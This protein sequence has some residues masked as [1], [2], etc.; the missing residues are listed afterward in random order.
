MPVVSVALF[1]LFFSANRSNFPDPMAI[2]WGLSGEPDGFGSLDGQLLM[3]SLV[4]LLVGGLWAGI[5]YLR[6]IP[7]SIR[8]LFLAITGVIWVL[9]FV[10]FGY[11]FLIQLGLSDAREAQINIVFFIAV[12]SLPLVLLPWLMSKPKIELGDQLGVYYWRVPILRLS[13]KEVS[14]VEVVEARA[15]DFGG[16]GIRYANR[17]TAFLPNSGP[18]VL[19]NLSGSER[20][21][22][23]TDDAS[24]IAK[25]IRKRSGL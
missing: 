6:R 24:G 22:I 3:V 10:V 8:V 18:G 16:W 20:V 14:S 19:L 17:T 13:Y 12:L 23:R 4:L 5:V 21:L 9:L 11:T 1:W 7:G 2:H 15:R 25:G